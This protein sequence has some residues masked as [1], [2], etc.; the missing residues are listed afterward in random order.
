MA[1]IGII[2]LAVLIEVFWF[3]FSFFASLV[4]PDV[5]SNYSIEGIPASDGVVISLSDGDN[6]F[7]ITG[8]DDTVKSIHFN[9]TIDNAA[10]SQTA[11][12][13][14]Q[15][16]MYLQDEGNAN[17]Y[18]LPT[19][20][21]DPS[22]PSSSYISLDPA[23]NCHSIKVTA[24]NLSSIG[25]ITVSGISLNT[26]V[27]FHFDPIRLFAILALLAA[28]FA[29]RPQAKIYAVVLDIRRSRQKTIIA[30]LVLLEL[31]VIIA[32][33]LSNTYYV[34]MTEAT[35]PANQTQYQKLAVALS[36]GHLY[37]DDVPSAA[38][39]SMSN[40]YDTQA[41][42]DQG[43]PYLW[44]H[45]YYQGKYYVYFGI[46]PCLIFYL[47]WYLVFGTGFPTWLG[48][49]ICA[50]IY[51]VGLAY[52]LMQ[53]CKRWFPR[54]SLGVFIVM[55][56][57]LLIGGGALILA[58][59]PTMY[60]MPEAVGLCCVA[61][62]LA[63]WVRGT[64]RGYIQRGYIVAGA[65]LIALTLAC[66][67]Q[68]VL[69]AVFGIFLIWPFK[70]A[71][72][73][74]RQRRAVRSAF[75]SALTPFLVVGFF[76]LLYNFL[77]FGS[78]FDFGANYNLTT[79]DMTHRGFHFDRIPFGLY[80]Y[81][82]QPPN[83]GSQFPFL[84]QTYLDPSYQGVTI[85]E[86]MFGGYFFLYPM[87]FILLALPKARRGLA[88]K[89]LFKPLLAAIGL[90]LV[91]CIFDLQA[92]GVLMR[93][94]CDFGIYFALAAV[95]VFL[96]LLQV[97]SSEP[98]HAGWTTDLY[99]GAGAHQVASAAES[100]GLTVSVYRIVLYFMY[101]SLILMLVAAVCLWYAFGMW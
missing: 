49:I 22:D 17:Y 55:D 33:V 27:P 98:L 85:T 10:A 84:R 31:A 18:S 6:S 50:C 94:M 16:V 64:S 2:A 35:L 39:Q 101:G 61:W 19:V 11:D 63:L 32:L 58:R 3:N 44:D 25:S 57:F 52:L 73:D 100:Q 71:A 80:A 24:T 30:C 93:Y 91:L 82:I 13:K 79:N 88:Q 77:R 38:L 37:L 12:P 68:M 53:I 5:T 1:V 86:S 95:F 90:G 67:P 54:T 97:R 8:L 75:T 69:A 92:A 9:M 42:I 14:V 36:E 78:P 70:K 48:I 45:A 76:V 83:V 21:V 28:L 41:R 7:E 20:T 34:N 81:L 62:G 56:V 23:G 26:Q 66:R 99:G 74:R 96:E 46:L 60:F 72:V 47:P 65:V 40:P 43:V 89:G 29:L 4:Y 15:V 59:S 87:S 51:A